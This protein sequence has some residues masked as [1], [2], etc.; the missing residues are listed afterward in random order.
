MVEEPIR[1]TSGRGFWD[2][3]GEGIRDWREDRRMAR[4]NK[5]PVGGRISEGVRGV[6]ERAID[7]GKAVK[8]GATGVGRGLRRT[9][10][11][12]GFEAGRKLY[13]FGIREIFITISWIIFIAVIVIGG[14]FLYRNFVTGDLERIYEQQIYT[15]IANSKLWLTMKQGWEVFLNP[16]TPMEVWSGEVDEH[17]DTKLGV[18]ITKFEPYQREFTKEDDVILFADVDVYG[19]PEYVE[20]LKTFSVGCK[21]NNITEGEV[22]P[23]KEYRILPFESYSPECRFGKYDSL[24]KPGRSA[25]AKLN[26]DYEFNTK[27]YLK[28]YFMDDEEKRSLLS[29]GVENVFEYYK[30]DEKSPVSSVYTAGP[31]EVALGVGTGERIQPVGLVKGENSKF[32]GITVKNKWDGKIKKINSLKLRLP[33]GVDL[34]V[35]ET[36]PFGSGKD[37]GNFVEYEMSFDEDIDTF[38]TFR[39]Y[40]N[41]DY[42]ILGTIALKQEYYQFEADYVYSAEKKTVVVFF[43]VEEGIGIPNIDLGLPGLSG[44][45]IRP[46]D[47]TKITSC[48]G[49]RTITEFHQGLDFSVPVGTPVR[50]VAAGSV[51]SICS[52]NCGGYGNNLQIDHGNGMVTQYGHL[53]SFKVNKGDSVNQ[54][55]IIGLSGGASGDPG[56]GLSTGPHLDLKF[57]VNGKMDNSLCYI[58]NGGLDLSADGDC[59]SCQDTRNKNGG[60][61]K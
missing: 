3:F 34:D 30:L 60:C 51:I 28:V 31:V 49:H 20:E 58:D 40:L 10:E 27:G 29:K 7:Y 12:G 13:R 43:G 6:G 41:V 57:I 9:W 42:G 14:L 53:S 44:K 39:C 61:Y 11:T 5:E 35:S 55:Q 47:A 33:K 8:E 21:L 37:V 32:L 24:G 16:T 15:P 4:A 25:I 1:R 22:V 38:K 59:C 45:F 23:M 19:F 54:G 56:A 52:G 26:V 36:C 50:A 46:V 2:I 48:Y 18:Y 17:V